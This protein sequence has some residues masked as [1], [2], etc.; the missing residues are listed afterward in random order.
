M[1]FEFVALLL[2][3]ALVEEIGSEKA[4]ELHNHC[5]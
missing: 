2:A 5:R 4:L 3:V 1:L